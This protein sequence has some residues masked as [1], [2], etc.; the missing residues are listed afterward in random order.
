MPVPLLEETLRS[1]HTFVGAE[2]PCEN[3]TIP[4][5]AFPLTRVSEIVTATPVVLELPSDRIPMLLWYNVVRVMTAW[6]LPPAVGLTKMPPPPAP[7]PFSEI[8]LSVTKSL[9]APFGVKLMP[10]P[11]ELELKPL[12][13]QFTACRAPLPR[14]K[15]PER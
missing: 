1:T 8:R 11:A 14:N 10:N 15:T 5:L 2:P 12:I 4:P 6:A 13:V 3:T 9:P 7:E